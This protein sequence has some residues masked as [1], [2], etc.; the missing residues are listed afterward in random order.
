MTG[1]G[2]PKRV[3]DIA[4][5]AENVSLVLQAGRPVGYGPIEDV[6]ADPSHP[7]VRGLADALKPPPR[8]RERR[9]QVAAGDRAQN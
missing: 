4:V 8:R 9:P 5:G 7:F 1:G 3:G 6:L 2:P